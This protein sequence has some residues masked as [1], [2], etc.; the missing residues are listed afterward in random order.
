ME[1]DDT[2]RVFNV[3]AGFALGV[4]VGAAV[5]LL[6]APESGERTRKRVIRIAAGARSSASHRLGDLADD[7]RSLVRSGKKRLG[8]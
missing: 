4:I 2:S 6:L 3:M 1:Y 8:L 5:A 7:A